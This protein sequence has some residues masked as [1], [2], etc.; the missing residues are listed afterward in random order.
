[1]RL[2]S[3]IVK[4]TRSE[5]TIKTHKSQN[6]NEETSK[7]DHPNRYDS[8]DIEINTTSKLSNFN[9]KLLPDNTI[10]ESM[11]S[12]IQSKWEFS[13]GIIHVLEII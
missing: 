6:Q 1:M 2:I 10:A 7:A 3:L 4:V 9:A 11:N 5:L 13:T 8:E 12:L